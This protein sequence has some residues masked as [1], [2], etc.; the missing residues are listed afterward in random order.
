[1]DTDFL[2]YS[3][4]PA[5]VAAFLELVTFFLSVST[6][7]RII[8]FLGSMPPRIGKVTADF[9]KSPMGVYQALYL[10][11]DEIRMIRH[12]SWDEAVWGSSAVAAEKP[13]PLRF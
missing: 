1:M 8:C 6:I 3:L 5:I 12:G 10:T 9:L 11:I 7:S 13:V 4:F 2:V